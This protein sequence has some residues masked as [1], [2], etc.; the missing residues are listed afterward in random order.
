MRLVI[1]GCGKSKIWDNDENHSVGPQRAEDTYTS[2]CSKVKRQLAVREGCDWMIL[3]A[4]YGFI[5]PDFIIPGAY[6]VTFKSE[7]TKPISM[8]ELTQQV[9][10]QKMGRYD[11]I[12][13]IAGIEYI[14]RIREA[15]QGRTVTIYTPFAGNPFGRQV[16][17]MEE[18]LSSGDLAHGGTSLF[19]LA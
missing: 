13:I 18:L 14:N 17:M 16:Q 11:E 15:F 2:N 19:G 5:A 6:D 10:D 4:K 9:K 3:S 7:S 1:I 12:A 8:P